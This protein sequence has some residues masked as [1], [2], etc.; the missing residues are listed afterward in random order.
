[1]SETVRGF[2]KAHLSDDEAV[3]K[4]GYPVLMDL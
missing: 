2:A 1:M 3:A 4:M